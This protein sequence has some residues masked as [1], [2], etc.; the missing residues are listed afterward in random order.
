MA[1]GD[2]LPHG[3]GSVNTYQR[4]VAILNRARS[5]RIL[6]FFRILLGG[7]S[8]WSLKLDGLLEREV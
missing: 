4:A 7:E 3:R 1:V 6:G 5:K 8:L 2:R